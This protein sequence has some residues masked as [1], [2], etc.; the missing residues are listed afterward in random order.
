MDSNS[1]VYFKIVEAPLH[2]VPL[3]DRRAAS[4]GGM[5]PPPGGS[6]GRRQPRPM[7]LVVRYTK[8]LNRDFAERGDVDGANGLI[9]AMV[10]EGVAPT[11]VSTSGIG[12][13]SGILGLSGPRARLGLP[14]RCACCCGS[15]SRRGAGRATHDG[16]RPPL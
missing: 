2:V 6:R 11:L 1:K 10:A 7:D 14:V 12:G 3:P 9:E 5:A 15:P 16:R 4:G 8:R 13:R